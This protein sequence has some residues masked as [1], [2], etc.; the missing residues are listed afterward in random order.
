MADEKRAIESLDD[1]ETQADYFALVMMKL[2]NLRD[3]ATQLE[4]NF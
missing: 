2:F 3:E 1:A 4:F